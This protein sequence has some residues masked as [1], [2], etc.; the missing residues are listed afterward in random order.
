MLQRGYRE[1]ELLQRGYREEVVIERR[2]VIELLQREVELL[3]R[4]YREESCC[5]REVELLQL[6]S[7]STELLLALV[8]RARLD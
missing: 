1:K 6:R 2:V 7:T 8:R 3:Q 4:G 5:Y